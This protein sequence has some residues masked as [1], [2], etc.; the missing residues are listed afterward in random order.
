MKLH[1]KSATYAKMYGAGG[2][3]LM[4]VLRK[5]NRRAP[6]RMIKK[7]WVKIRNGDY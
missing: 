7:A 3:K 2:N 4:Q 6:A 1:T 5:E